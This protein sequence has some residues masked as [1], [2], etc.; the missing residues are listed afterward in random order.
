MWTQR[1]IASKWIEHDNRVT[2]NRINKHR[3]CDSQ[4][5]KSI[6]KAKKKSWR[7]SLSMDAGC[8]TLYRHTAHRRCCA[9]SWK[10]AGMKINK[11]ECTRAWKTKDEKRITC[12]NFRCRLVWARAILYSKIYLSNIAC[13]RDFFLF[14][15]NIANT[16][17]SMRLVGTGYGCVETLYLFHMKNESDEENWLVAFVWQ[18]RRRAHM[19]H[20]MLLFSLQPAETN[21][22]AMWAHT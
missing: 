7:H 22:C 10:V 21:V 19:R 13:D 1:I 6:W 3:I 9:M 11:H 16:D 17:C 5:G 2:S 15:R 14:I 20:V 8:C 4:N 12:N 18:K